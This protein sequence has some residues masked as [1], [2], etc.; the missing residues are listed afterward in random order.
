MFSLIFLLQLWVKVVSIFMWFDPLSW[1]SHLSIFQQAEG[2]SIEKLQPNDIE[3][4]HF[5]L[6]L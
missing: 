5:T 6:D 2:L 4:G 3:F 1:L